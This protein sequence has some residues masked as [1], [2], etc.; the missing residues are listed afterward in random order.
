MSAILE[1][2]PL[3]LWNFQEEWED[4]NLLNLIKRRRDEKRR[5]SD[6]MNYP[7]DIP[8]LQIAGSGELG[9]T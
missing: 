9:W 1:L 7:G 6:L 4:R 3:H 5:T 8:I 2:D